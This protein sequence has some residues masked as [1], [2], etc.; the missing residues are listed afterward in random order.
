M[1]FVKD[2]DSANEKNFSGA[3]GELEALD[4]R[5]FRWCRKHYDTELGNG[6]WS[7]SLPSIEPMD[8]KEWE[9]YTDLV[10]PKCS[11]QLNITCVR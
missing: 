5:M 4:L 10:L 9:E 6:F 11:W 2:A 3:K 7:N 1:A 8:G